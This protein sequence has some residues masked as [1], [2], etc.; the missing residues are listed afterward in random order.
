MMRSQKKKVL[1][2]AATPLW[3]RIGMVGG[4]KIDKIVE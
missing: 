2:M 3:K 1:T 4:S